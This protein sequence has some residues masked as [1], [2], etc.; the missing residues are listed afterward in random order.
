[1][2][3]PQQLPQGR[4]SENFRTKIICQICRPSTNVSVCKLAI[5]GLK[6]L[7]FPGIHTISPYKNYN[8]LIKEDGTSLIFADESWKFANF[9]L[10]HL[11]NLQLCNSEMSPRIYGFA[12]CRLKKTSFPSSVIWEYRMKHIS[13][14]LSSLSC[15]QL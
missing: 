7:K 5:F 15:P 12:I 9:E 3:G 6:K 10:T 13:L 8:A 14:S 4:K 2:D 1:M 11:R